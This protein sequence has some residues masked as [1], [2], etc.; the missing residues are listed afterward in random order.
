[1]LKT[2]DSQKI[3][4]DLQKYKTAI[5]SIADEQTKQEY[6][7][8]FNKLTEQFKLIDAAHD[9]INRDI[10]PAQVREN[11]EQS[12]L[13]RKKLDRMLKDLKDL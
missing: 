11:V 5:A 3:Q 13:L 8:I 1:M 12:I 10:D 4:K 6:Q 9:A 7:T 2:K